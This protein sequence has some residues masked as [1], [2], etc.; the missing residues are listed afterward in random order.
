MIHNI[1][2][3]AATWA[4]AI[5]GAALVGKAAESFA[6]AQAAAAD[7][8]LLDPAVLAAPGEGHPQYAAYLLVVGIGGILTTL[9]KLVFDDRRH[10]RESDVRSL[11]EEVARLTGEVAGLEKR[12]DEDAER[13]RLSAA[14]HV[15]DRR[16]IAALRA[17][18]DEKRTLVAALQK[19]IAALKARQ[20]PTP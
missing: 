19:E 1:F 14:E 8:P 20:D 9:A 15:E 2:G 16:E 3:Q 18:L 13:Q 7:P 5:A 6:T 11:K 17:D 12:R 10:D 4:A